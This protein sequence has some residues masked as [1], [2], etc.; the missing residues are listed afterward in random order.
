MISVYGN[1][2]SQLNV[3][4]EH[5]RFAVKGLI[6][7]CVFTFCVE[8]ELVRLIVNVVSLTS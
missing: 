8:V 4:M 1:I 6:M 7:P 3:N 2:F 5:G